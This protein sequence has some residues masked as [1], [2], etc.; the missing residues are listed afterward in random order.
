M[1]SMPP[2][3]TR[4]KSLARWKSEGPTGQVRYWSNAPFW[5]RLYTHAHEGLVWYKLA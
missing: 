2:M 4:Y 5:Y 3:E 1:P